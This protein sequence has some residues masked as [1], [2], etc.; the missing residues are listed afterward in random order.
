MLVDS[1][2]GL[3]FLLRS[4]RMPLLLTGRRETCCCS[5]ESPSAKLAAASLLPLFLAELGIAIPDVFLLVAPESSASITIGRV[6]RGG[7]DGPE[8]VDDDLTISLRAAAIRALRYRGSGA[9]AAR[10][11]FGDG[12]IGVCCFI[13][14]FNPADPANTELNSSTFSCGKDSIISP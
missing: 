12:N 11:G 6:G 10:F 14:G 4:M 7:C 5:E 1:F 13:I 9:G 3:I 2:K 8:V